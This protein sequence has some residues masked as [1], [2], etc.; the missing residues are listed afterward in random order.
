M[1][2]GIATSSVFLLCG[3]LEGAV[4]CRCFIPWRRSVILEGYEEKKAQIEEIKLKYKRNF[5]CR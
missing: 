2:V 3:H 5:Q 4:S 1:L